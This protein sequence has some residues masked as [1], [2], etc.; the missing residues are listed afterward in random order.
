MIRFYFK[1]QFLFFLLYGVFAFAQSTIDESAY[2]AFDEIIGLENTTFF[3]GAE[4]K[5]EFPNAD[6][7]SRYFNLYTFAYGSIEYGGQYYSKIP[8]EYD[9]FS[10]N[11]ITSSNDYLSDFIVT[12]IPEY[13]T[14]FTIQGHRFVKL[15]A[16][17][18]SFDD[19]GFYEV[20][21]NG[22]PFTL[23]IKHVRRKKERTAGYEVEH[24][25]S[26]ENHYVVQNEDVYTKV[27]SIKD[28][29]EVVPGRYKEVQKFRKDYKSM[30]KSDTEGFMIKLVKHLNGF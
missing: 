13:V 28:F 21:V 6:G 24:S 15:Q 30:Y 23:Y 9:I 12:L 2:K 8:L 1:T 4:F 11:V 25:F 3:N 17:N 22:T 26:N 27:N 7:D 14:H 20:A 10:D 16:Q 18:L 5:D 29:K 19:N